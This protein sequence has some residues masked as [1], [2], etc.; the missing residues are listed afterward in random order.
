MVAPVQGEAGAPSTGKSVHL[1]VAVRLNMTVFPYTSTWTIPASVCACKP[2][3]AL[4][5]T[6]LAAEADLDQLPKEVTVWKGHLS[7]ISY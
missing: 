1:C 6:W 3:W 4:P 7:N 5:S 2:N